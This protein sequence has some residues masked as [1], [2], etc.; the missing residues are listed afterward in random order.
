MKRKKLILSESGLID[1]ICKTVLEVSNINEGGDTDT[2]MPTRKSLGLGGKTALDSKASSFV[3]AQKDSSEHIGHTDYGYSPHAGWKQF[4]VDWQNDDFY[5]GDKHSQ[6]CH[7]CGLGYHGYA[8]GNIDEDAKFSYIQSG[9]GDLVADANDIQSYLKNEV[10]DK[11]KN[12][13]TDGDFGNETAKAIG[14]YLGYPNIT[15]EEKLL[16]YLAPK[17]PDE[18]GTKGKSGYGI[19]GKSQGIIADLL[20]AKCVKDLREC[21]EKDNF[22]T[23]HGKTREEFADMFW[24]AAVKAR[25]EAI[26]WIIEFYSDKNPDNFNKLIPEDEEFKDFYS[27]WTL[28]D[29]V[30][31]MQNNQ[32]LGLSKYEL[33]GLNDLRMNVYRKLRNKLEEMKGEEKYETDLDYGV[34]SK[35][36]RIFFCCEG[37]FFAWVNDSQ[38][39]YRYNVNLYTFL[40]PSEEGWEHDMFSSTLHELGHIVDNILL[41]DLGVKPYPGDVYLN[42]EADKYLNPDEYDDEGNLETRGPYVTRKSELYARMFNLRHYFDVKSTISGEAW[43][44]AW[45]KKVKKGDIIWNPE[46]TFDDLPVPEFGLDEVG[47]VVYLELTFELVCRLWSGKR[48]QK[49]CRDPEKWTYGDIWD[50]T[51]MIKYKIGDKEVFSTEHGLGALLATFTFDPKQFAVDNK[52]PNKF[53][54]VFDMSKIAEANRLYVMIDPDELVDDSEEFAAL[55]ALYDGIPETI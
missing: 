55:E 54:V 41:K 29:I 13:G 37:D 6:Y 12:L 53:W 2:V 42:P 52:D 24:K 10:G 44:Q 48:W 33:Q 21:M 19:G 3:K 46:K 8:E 27:L 17:Y 47:D 25:T 43:A 38:S 11:Y 9:T 34:F 32:D 22:A 18:F 16:E 4:W 7:S 28:Q 39:L 30:A 14:T 5:I 51:T 31:A 26:D 50:F 35:S 15:S 1:L 36:L 20:S 49:I 40:N 45:M 23:K